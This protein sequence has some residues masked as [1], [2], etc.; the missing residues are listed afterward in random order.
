MLKAPVPLRKGLANLKTLA[1]LL[2][3]PDSSIACSNGLLR[4]KAK[5]LI[6]GVILDFTL[7]H[8][9]EVVPYLNKDK[10]IAAWLKDKLNK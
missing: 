9:K 6:V 8:S 7:G 2:L 3:S 1:D 4:I 10:T 5:E